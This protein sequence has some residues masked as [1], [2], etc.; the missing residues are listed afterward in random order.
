MFRCKLK[1]D[2]QHKKLSLKDGL[3]I[4]E[5]GEILSKLAKCLEKDGV[6]FILVDVEESSYTPCIETVDQEGE[7]RFN[8]LHSL[9]RQGS[10]DDLSNEQRE[11]ADTLKRVLFDKGITLSAIDSKNEEIPIKSITKKSF[12]FTSITTVT[13]RIVSLSGANEKAPNFT[14]KT[15]RETYK[16]N[17]SVEQEKSL[18]KFYKEGKIRARIKL[19]IKST[20]ENSFARL[21]DYEIL[22]NARF[23]D[24]IKATTEKF[25]DIFKNIQDSAKLLK[26]LRS[27]EIYD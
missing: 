9:I 26:E 25:G 13:G 22:G 17:I 6:K 1:I 23:I 8:E 24:S 4:K 5:L 10:Y 20:N 15:A 27:N 19:P 11:Y 12:K 2:G 18:K 21:I 3:S 16:I 14:L 7:Q